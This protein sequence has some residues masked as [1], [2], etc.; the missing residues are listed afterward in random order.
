[1]LIATRYKLRFRIPESSQLRGSDKVTDSQMARLLLDAV[2]AGLLGPD[3]IFDVVS[4][5]KLLYLQM[6]TANLNTM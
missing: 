3:F 5:G 1:M 4:N 6:P 2:L